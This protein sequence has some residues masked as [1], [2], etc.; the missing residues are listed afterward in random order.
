MQAGVAGETGL[1]FIAGK[2]NAGLR[3][4]RAIQSQFRIAVADLGF[5]ALEV[6]AA[7]QRRKQ[8]HRSFVIA[9]Q[10][11]DSI[12]SFTEELPTLRAVQQGRV[13]P[14]RDPTVLH[15]SQLVGDS[16]RR[17]AELIHPEAFEQR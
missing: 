7:D 11:A 6:L 1:N 15:P 13:Y 4:S 16:A 12:V 14:V 3:E 17:F 9:S 10:L 8:R 2:P 5:L